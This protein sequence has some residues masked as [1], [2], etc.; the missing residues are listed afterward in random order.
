MGWIPGQGTK[1]P[2]ATQLKKKITRH[3]KETARIKVWEQNKTKKKN[4]TKK[5]KELQRRENSSDEALSPCWARWEG[6]M[7][8]WGIQLCLPHPW[9]SRPKNSG[10]LPIPSTNTSWA[11]HPMSLVWTC[12]AR[13][14]CW[15]G[16]GGQRALRDVGRGARPLRKG[17]TQKGG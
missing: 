6:K 12:P 10:Y 14:S 8:I 16:G 13:E 2:H 11:Y 7:L 3:L 9:A 5:Q 1:S 17:E 15:K 4:K